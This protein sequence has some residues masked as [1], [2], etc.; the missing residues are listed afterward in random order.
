MNLKG[1]IASMRRRRALR[2]ARRGVALVR[3][4]IDDTSL[5]RSTRRRIMRA[6]AAGQVDPSAIFGDER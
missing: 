2:L 4:A 6:F 1:L 3:A 5:P